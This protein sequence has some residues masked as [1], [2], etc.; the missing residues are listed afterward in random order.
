MW[1]SSVSDNPL[2]KLAYIGCMSV[3]STLGD[4]K[5]ALAAEKH[6]VEESIKFGR[7][8]PSDDSFTAFAQEFLRHQKRRVAPYSAK[9]RITDAEFIRQKGIIEQHL[10][11]FFGD[12]K[13]TAI[14]KARVLDYIN[15]RMGEGASD[16]TIIKERNVL[17]RM[18]NIAIDKDK[19]SVNP[20]DG[21]SLRGHM[22]ADR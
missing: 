7:P 12:D 3:L 4:A 19:I 18:F 6:K 22:P 15:G 21:R 10:V 13:I 20:A 9:D 11:P 1:S 5:S 8:L 17:R 16:G 14:R 2:N